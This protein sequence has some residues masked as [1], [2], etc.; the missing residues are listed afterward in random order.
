MEQPERKTRPVMLQELEP[1]LGVT[2]T[3]RSGVL[4]LAVS[5]SDL[6]HNLLAPLQDF[7]PHVNH[8]DFQTRNTKF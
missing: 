3:Q 2:L 7:C 1:L 6:C 8:L 5:V 4:S